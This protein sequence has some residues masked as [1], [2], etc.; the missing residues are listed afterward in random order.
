MDDLTQAAASATGAVDSAIEAVETF[1]D[2][3]A[4]YFSS[5]NPM[6]LSEALVPMAKALDDLQTAKP[7]AA[8]DVSALIS[9]EIAPFKST[10]TS[11]ASAIADLQAQVSTLAQQVAKATN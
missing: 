3:A 8:V 1:A 9:A 2:K 11:Q 5:K 10:I 4:K 6:H 7:G